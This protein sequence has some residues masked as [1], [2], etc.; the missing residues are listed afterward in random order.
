MH[1][2]NPSRA[3]R[4]L[5]I[6]TFVHFCFLEI[7]LLSSSIYSHPCVMIC[8]L[9]QLVSLS[10]LSSSITDFFHSI[11]PD[12]HELVMYQNNLF[13]IFVLYCCHWHTHNTHAQWFDSQ[14]MEPHEAICVCVTVCVS[15]C[16][17]RYSLFSAE[18]IMCVQQQLSVITFGLLTLWPQWLVNCSEEIFH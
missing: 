8:S 2:K 14:M 7:I 6:L 5:K 1:H 18:I 3:D 4:P 17:S 9:I 12:A 13:I 10:S 15:V 11:H 16:V